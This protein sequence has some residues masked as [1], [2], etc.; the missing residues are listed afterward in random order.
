MKKIDF[1]KG[2]F[3][4]IAA[5]DAEKVHSQTIGWILSDECEVFSKEERKSIIQ[6]L[7][8]GQSEKF[9]IGCIE[10]VDVEI[11]DIDIQIT[12]KNCLIVIENKLKSSQH[13]NQL[14]KYEYLTTNNKSEARH[15]FLQWKFPI[16]YKQWIKENS[17]V[18]DK[19][20]KF[21]EF[22]KKNLNKEKEK[23]LNKYFPNKVDIILNKEDIK[24]V[25]YFY[26]TLSDEK[27]K[28]TAGKW[29][30]VKYKK[31]F[32]VLEKYNKQVS[33]KSHPNYSILKNYIETLGRLT[34]ATEEFL[35]CPEGEKM[36]FVFTKG[37]TKKGT[38]KD[39]EVICIYSYIQN[40]QL[41]TLLQKVY[42]GKLLKDVEE[43]LEEK[44]KCKIESSNVSETRG[45]ALLDFF[46]E[47]VTIGNITYIPVLQFQGKAIKLGLTEKGVF[48]NG[49]ASPEAKNEI[50]NIKARKDQFAQKLI[51]S[52]T[53]I[54]FFNHPEI[55]KDEIQ[56]KLSNPRRVFGFLSLPLIEEENYLI[57]E[58]GYWQ[59]NNKITDKVKFITDYIELACK[60]FKEIN[61]KKE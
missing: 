41:E 7:F 33:D 10:S 51:G 22:L 11:N 8:F 50:N 16:E 4:W 36:S 58:E 43:K 30:N 61:D 23:I 44:L 17:D 20:I 19:G 6:E 54:D 9:D 57:E 40:L 13:S 3:E 46:F 12:C 34:T 32:E 28:G 2:F 35:E 15:Y 25:K 26:L 52:K 42:Y 55:K 21:L 53:F 45:N 60:V 31:L 48:Q 14:F 39:K 29:V 37:K 59:I 38:I 18:T 49:I 47:D 5:A 24:D 1:K 56:K 27:P